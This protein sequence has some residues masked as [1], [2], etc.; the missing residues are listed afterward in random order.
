MKPPTPAAVRQ[1][2]LDHFNDQELNDLCYDHFEEVY[3]S[4][5]AGMDQ[6]QRVLALVDYCR[7]HGCSD[8]LLAH[9]RRLRPKPYQAWFGDEGQ[10][11]PA[12]PRRLVDLNRASLFELMTL[13]EVGLKRAGEIIEGRPYASVEELRRVPGI[14]P[15]R[16]AA[17]SGRCTV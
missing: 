17:L 10:Q 5:T 2:I 14:G 1:F 15:K 8:D 11:E 6:N 9:I 3:Q 16:F 7:R 13:P 4:F 12:S